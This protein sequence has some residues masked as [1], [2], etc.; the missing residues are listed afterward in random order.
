MPGTVFTT[1]DDFILGGLDDHKQFIVNEAQDFFKH[2]KFTEL[3]FIAEDGQVARCNLALG[4][5]SFV[6]YLFLLFCFCFLVS[7]KV[8]E[9]Q[10]QSVILSC[11]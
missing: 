5:P 6:L 2:N 11:S 1:H 7:V 3:V 4:M 9:T 8:I 10:N